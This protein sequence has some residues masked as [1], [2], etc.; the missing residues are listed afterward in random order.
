MLGRIEGY[1]YIHKRIAKEKQTLR[2]RLED[3][4]MAAWD[5]TGR[6]S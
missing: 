4:E 3:L 2:E 1:K 6:G 5:C